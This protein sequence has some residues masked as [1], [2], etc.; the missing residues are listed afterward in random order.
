MNSRVFARKLLAELPKL[1]SSGV[2]D[3]DSSLKLR[4]YYEPKAADGANLTVLVFAAL[5]ALLIGGGLIL[6]VA[7]NWYELGRHARA[8]LSIL[9]L[10]FCQI[11]SLWVVLTG[12]RGGAWSEGTG[13]AWH[14]TTGAAIALISQTYHIGGTVPDFLFGWALLTI[15]VTYLIS[16]VGAFSLWVLTWSAWQLSAFAGQMEFS[17]LF[18]PVSLIFLPYI[19]GVYRDNRYG[20][21]AALVSLAVVAL[22]GAGCFSSY[23]FLKGQMSV[24]LAPLAATSI[25]LM[26]VNCFKEAE[27]PR[28][29]PLLSLGALAVAIL[30]LVFSYEDIWRHVM[31]RY[32]YSFRDFKG[33]PGWWTPYGYANFALFL[34][35]W[36]ALLFGALKNKVYHA[37]S[38][39]LLPA[40]VFVSWLLNKSMAS[41][42]PGVI[43]INIYGLAAGVFLVTRASKAGSIWALNRAMAFI[44]TLIAL[45]FFDSDLSILLKGVSFIIIGAIFLAANFKMTRKGRVK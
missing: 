7:H 34:L 5:G 6:L 10:L 41:Y 22:T 13:I 20:G 2:L 15:P 16:S 39:G 27:N 14:L 37:L 11:M 26:G 35:S 19:M 4:E 9:P 23:L 12:R 24:Y 31:S 40:A 33:A 29:N 8:V 30:I 3:E 18:W 42:F 28:Q 25:Y 38:F 21:R 32:A 45:R 17:W 36:T 43:I 44:A 1:V